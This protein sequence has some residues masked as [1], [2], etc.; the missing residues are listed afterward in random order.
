MKLNCVYFCRKFEEKGG[1]TDT[2]FVS[3]GETSFSSPR[4]PNIDGMVQRVAA[5]GEGYIYSQNE[6]DGTYDFGCQNYKQVI[7]LQENH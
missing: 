4:P 1:M 7:F 5:S 3:I 6:C 2:D